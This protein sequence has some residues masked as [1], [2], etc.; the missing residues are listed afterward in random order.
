M[1]PSETAARS[2][3]VGCALPCADVLVMDERGREVE[4]GT[5]GEIWLGGPMVV[6]GYWDNPQATASHVLSATEV[7]FGVPAIIAESGR[8]GLVEE[9]AIVRH[10]NPCVSG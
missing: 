9:D 7:R 8:C 4:P 10:V 2:D 3:S 6:R 1:P 5:Q